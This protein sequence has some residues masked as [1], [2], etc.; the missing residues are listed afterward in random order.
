MQKNK[1]ENLIFLIG[2][3]L[4]GFVFLITFIRSGIKKEAVSS[5]TQIDTPVDYSITY[6][7]DLN[8]KIKQKSGIQIVDLRSQSDFAEEHIMDSINIPQENLQKEGDILDPEKETIL[9]TYT[10]SKEA[11]ANSVKLLESNGFNN[12]SV[13]YNGM[14]GWKSGLFSTV[15]NGNPDSILDQSKIVYIS[16][17]EFQSALNT[18]DNLFI[19]DV[20]EPSEF[21][22]E[23]IHNSINIPLSQLETRKNKISK[24]KEIIVY[25]KD[26]TESFQAGSKL[27]DL[28]F[29]TTKTLDG[30]FDIW[31]EFVANSTASKEST[32]TTSE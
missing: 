1:K 2:I 19:L 24:L 15:A 26:A 21:E 23:N 18:D 16:L 22:K 9:V 11:I 8:D 25:G 27:F 3:L 7:K 12:V 13:L 32:T 6:S 4:I 29:F 10:D 28:G 31:K 20:R 30:G 14:E 5:D 17:E